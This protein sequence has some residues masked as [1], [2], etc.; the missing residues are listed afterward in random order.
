[1]RLGEASVEYTGD[2]L[3]AMAGVGVGVTKKCQ[4]E[5]FIV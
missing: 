5:D 3:L 1:M 2:A 4:A